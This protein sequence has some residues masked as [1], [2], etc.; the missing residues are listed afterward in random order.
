MRPLD[1]SPNT[2]SGCLLALAYSYVSGPIELTELK[3]SSSAP[4]LPDVTDALQIVI[5][6]QKRG[7]E[8][9]I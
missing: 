8:R 3:T 9:V 1:M 5:R 4:C 7:K 2:F 6:A